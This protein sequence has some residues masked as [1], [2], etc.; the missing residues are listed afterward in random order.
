MKSIYVH[1]AL[2][3]DW[4]RVHVQ[5]ASF[6]IVLQGLDYVLPATISR[7]S[8]LSDGI[9]VILSG[10]IP[11][12]LKNPSWFTEL[13]MFWLQTRLRT[14]LF[15]LSRINFPGVGS[16]VAPMSSENSQKSS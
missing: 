7:Q 11:D 12:P 6:Q 8:L 10:D 13:N 15:F 14:E 5:T 16:W 2:M 3:V 1:A 9:I 4:L